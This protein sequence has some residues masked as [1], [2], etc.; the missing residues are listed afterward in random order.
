MSREDQQKISVAKTEY[1]EA[2]NTA[3]VERL[4]P[5]FASGFTDCSEGEPSFYG[6]EARRALRLRTE[7]LFRRYSVELFV[8]IIDIV[9]KGDFAYDWGWHKVRLTDKTGGE[10][11]ETKYRYLETWTKED[12]AWKINYI[13][14]NKELPP[15][16]LPEEPIALE[17]V[18]REEA[19]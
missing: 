15:R 3:D 14:T 13:I 18:S 1:R 19:G 2:Y 6:E 5:V 7:E 9:V 11:T 17:A 16:M 10:T 12:G 8:I 4:L